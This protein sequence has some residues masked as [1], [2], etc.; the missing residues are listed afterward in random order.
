MWDKL[1][2]TTTRKTIMYCKYCLTDTAKKTGSWVRGKNTRHYYLCDLCGERW[3][4]DQD[5]EEL[6]FVPW[7]SFTWEWDINEPHE[8]DE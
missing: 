1:G 8:G 4:S 7:D 3:T 6:D 2:I 5:P